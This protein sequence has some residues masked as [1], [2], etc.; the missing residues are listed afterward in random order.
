VQWVKV[1]HELHSPGTFLLI[2]TSSW[3]RVLR[4]KKQQKT[5]TTTAEGVLSISG[6]ERR[7]VE[8]F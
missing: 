4:N 6:A 1:L 5:P 3:A 8:T 2:Q 7:E